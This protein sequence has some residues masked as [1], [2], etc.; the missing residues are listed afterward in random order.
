MHERHADGP[1]L[2]LRKP[3][4]ELQL[5][6][7]PFQLVVFDAFYVPEEI[8]LDFTSAYVG[9][10][11]RRFGREVIHFGYAESAVQSGRQLPGGLDM[12]EVVEVL[13]RVGAVVGKLR[14]VAVPFGPEV[15]CLTAYDEGLVSF[16]L[17][18]LG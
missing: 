3:Y 8:D 11:N 13:G 15:K 9:L 6:G 7:S 5:N 4:V 2:A 16:Q 10:D 1:C 12:A 18:Y 14:V 17:E